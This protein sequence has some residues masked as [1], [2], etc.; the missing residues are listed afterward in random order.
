[1][2]DIQAITLIVLFR[3]H[4]LYSLDITV[5]NYDQLIDTIPSF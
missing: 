4:F 3:F 5:K 1:V 2:G